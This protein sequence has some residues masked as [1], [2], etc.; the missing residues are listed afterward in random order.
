MWVQVEVPWVLSSSFRVLFD[1]PDMPESLDFLVLIFLCLQASSSFCKSLTRVAVS[2]LTSGFVSDRSSGFVSERTSGFVSDRTSGFG[3][4]GLL[5]LTCTA[6]LFVG[7]RELATTIFWGLFLAVSRRLLHLSDIGL[8]LTV[9][10]WRLDVDAGEVDEDESVEE[11]VGILEVV[12]E[13]SFL[14]LST[15]FLS[16]LT[17]V[18]SF[19]FS[20]F[21]AW[22]LM[23]V[24]GRCFNFSSSS[25]SDVIDRPT[26]DSEKGL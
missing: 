24:F 16:G 6:T 21:V 2:D 9:L 8:L 25:M 10:F 20:T 13:E 3:F 18:P 22:I 15:N 5:L 23:T 7:A 12:G 1:L 11:V 4:C 14:I 17:S 26:D 19:S